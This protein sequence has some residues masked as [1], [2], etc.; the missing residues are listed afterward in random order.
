VAR[1][2]YNRCQIRSTCWRQYTWPR[3]AE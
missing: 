1:Q 3:F 2:D